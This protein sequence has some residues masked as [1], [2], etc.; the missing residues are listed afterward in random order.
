MRGFALL[1]A[2]LCAPALVPEAFAQAAGL[3]EV[4]DRFYPADRLKPA[5]A[6]ERR[7]CL[8]VLDATGANEPAAV[9]AVYAD[10]SNGA[11]RVLRRND[12]G[13]FEPVYDHP[14]GWTLPGTRTRC[15]IR[16]H[17]VDFDG[18]AEAFVYFEGV[19][20]SVGWIFRW[21]GSRLTSLTPTRSD[22]TR[23][24]SLL[25]N[26][27]V[28]DLD[29]AGSLRVIAARDIGAPPPGVPAPYPAFVYRL[30]PSGFEPEASILAVMGFRADV[31]PRGNLRSFRTVTDSSPPFTL[32]IVNGD[33]SGR[34]R[35][36]GAT[37]TVNGTEAVGPAQ[38]ND[39]TEF[40][41]AALPPLLVQNHVTATLT[42]PPDAYI[43][44][45]VQDGT[46]R[47]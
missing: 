16:M 35:V 30:G 10:R 22:G 21:D 9:L 43:L 12:A 14:P 8:Q 5:D 39:R 7:S 11:V 38:V 25:I 31:D 2:F 24:S 34:H 13:A 45:L 33:R 40:T 19:R 32:R 18:R 23:E 41:S 1:A 44:V 28:Y 36:A 37:I 3:Q 29:H 20:A 27:A 42:G 15:V 46:T 26:P 17:D 4:V 47:P 6:A